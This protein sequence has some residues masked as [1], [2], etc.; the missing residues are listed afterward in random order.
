MS[1][2]YKYVSLAEERKQRINAEPGFEWLYDR[3]TL[4]PVK[5]QETCL[6]IAR[7]RTSKR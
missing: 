3:L 7:K 5:V 4:L 2:N 6:V 1:K